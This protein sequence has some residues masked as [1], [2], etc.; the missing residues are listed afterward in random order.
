MRC[1]NAYCF[2]V[3]VHQ[4]QSKRF[5]SEMTSFPENSYSFHR[6]RLKLVGQLDYKALYIQGI[7]FR[8]YR[9]TVPQSLI[10]VTSGRLC[11]LF[12]ATSSY[13]CHR[14]GLK[15]VR[16]RDDIGLIISSFQYTKFWLLS[17][18]FWCVFFFF[19]RFFS[20]DLV[21]GFLIFILMD[22]KTKRWYSG[23]CF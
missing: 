2:D 21:S 22:T 3:R 9:V 15:L 1:Y 18:F 5:F 6:M 13:S 8:G 10:V 4:R 17:L 12:P 11:D 14:I 16:P 7:L 23:Y 19:L 20:H